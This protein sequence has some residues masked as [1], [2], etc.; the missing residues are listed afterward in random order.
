MDNEKIV[1]KA[2]ETHC[3]DNLEID[4]GAAISHAD[5]G[6]WVQAWVWVS[7]DE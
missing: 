1:E 6:A 3:D 7:Y 2:R 4:E 5:D